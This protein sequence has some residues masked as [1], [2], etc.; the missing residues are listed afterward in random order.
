MSRRVS[1]MK[2]IQSNL[3][4]SVIMAEMA[5]MSEDQVHDI[6]TECYVEAREDAPEGS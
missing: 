6:V 4:E 5:G 3:E 1:M 2:T